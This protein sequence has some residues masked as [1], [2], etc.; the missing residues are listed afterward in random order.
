MLESNHLSGLANTAMTKLANIP[1]T[2]RPRDKTITSHVDSA[3]EFDKMVRVV[4]EGGEGLRATMKRFILDYLVTDN[5]GFMEIMGDGPPD[6]PIAGMPWGIRHLDSLRCRRTGSAKYPVAFID[7][8]SDN[9]R[10][11]LHNS[12][13]IYFAQQPSSHKRGVGFSSVSRS[14]L[15]GEV[16]K[17]QIVYKMEKM[18]SRPNTKVFVGDG[19]PAEKMMAAFVAA[20]TLQDNLGLEYFGKNVFIGG[21]GAALIATDLNNFDP[22]DEETGTLMAMYAI[23]FCWG[24]KIQ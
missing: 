19:L 1:L 17:S 14:N 20:N 21:E 8:K 13:V 15:L 11:K 10:Y 16:L 18:G 23:A 5:G 12:R 7:P 24:L 6:G 4:S 2:F 3:I 22:F 9:K